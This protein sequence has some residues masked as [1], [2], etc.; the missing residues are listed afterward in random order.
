M[1]SDCFLEVLEKGIVDG[2]KML[3]L[4]EIGIVV[5]RL[6]RTKFGQRAVRPEIHSP[7]QGGGDV[8]TFPLFPNPAYSPPKPAAL[9]AAIE[10]A[11][12]NPLSDIR[13]GAIRPL[14]QFLNSDDRELARLA[15]A[16]LERLAADDDSRSVQQGAQD[17]LGRPQEASEDN[18]PPRL[19][20]RA[21]AQP[22]AERPQPKQAAPK[23]ARLVVIASL[24]VLVLGAGL[25]W[26][27]YDPGAHTDLVTQPMDEKSQQQRADVPHQLQ[28]G[29]L[30]SPKA[31]DALES[32]SAVRTNGEKNAEKAQ[33]IAPAYTEAPRIPAPVEKARSATRVDD[34]IL[35]LLTDARNDLQQDRL[36]TPEGN[37]AAERYRAVISIEPDNQAAREGLI[38]VVSRYVALANGALAR[39][40]FQKAEEYLAKAEGIAPANAE[41]ASARARIEKERAT[42]EKRKVIERQLA[43][44]ERDPQQGPLDSA[45]GSNALN[46]PAAPPS[47]IAFAVFPFQTLANCHYSVRDEVTEAADSV[48]RHQP[49]A[50]LEY[51]YYEEG[52]DP[53]LIPAVN[54]LWSENVA[55]RDPELDIVR[56]AGRELG[57]NGVL[58]AWYKCSQSQHVSADTYE[59][60]LYLID[61]N[62]DQVFHAKERL[63]DAKRAVST[64][65]EQFFTT[66]SGRL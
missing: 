38:R 13:Q 62:S 61:I 30:D 60:E 6:V 9:P 12:R 25:F 40:D 64:V 39:Q 20:K 48:I 56:K 28:A 45:K 2:R 16:E 24:A 27:F 41:L 51:S 35:R 54:E 34:R 66:Y 47:R 7:R 44:A 59:V 65:F 29:R 18:K 52:A 10:D 5:Q 42:A 50:L 46:R 3:S 1:F 58:M 31:D 17:A 43:T 49:G 22:R 57:V 63:L 36:T 55:R 14:A 37:N 15:R 26:G 33:H 19:A 23:R 32:S 8:A 53:K 4:A 21:P 11:L